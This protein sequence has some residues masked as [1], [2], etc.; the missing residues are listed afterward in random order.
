MVTQAAAPTATLTGDFLTLAGLPPAAV[1]DILDLAAHLKRRPPR[2]G[3]E[4]RGM[5]VALLFEKPSLRT[6]TTFEVGAF[7]LGGH[8][9]HLGREV[10]ELG[11]R[12]TVADVARNLERWVDLIV[13]RTF[14]QSRLE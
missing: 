14:A 9:I 4:L 10:G 3:D 6:R 2:M 7:Q 12:E 11:V 8:P 5:T 1:R 13:V